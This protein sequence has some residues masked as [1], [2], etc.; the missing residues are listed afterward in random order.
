MVSNV[1]GQPRL[2][3]FIVIQCVVADKDCRTAY[4]GRFIYCLILR[5][6]MEIVL[7]NP[8]FLWFLSDVDYCTG[9]PLLIICI[10]V[11]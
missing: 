4:L 5:V 8:S 2:S 9:Y 6:L 11:G 7:C 10:T 1:Q 3:L